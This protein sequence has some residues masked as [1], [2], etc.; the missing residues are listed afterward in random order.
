MNKPLASFSA[1]AAKAGVE[2]SL[3]KT[4][5]IPAKTAEKIL[6]GLL[7]RTP[8]QR[9]GRKRGPPCFIRLMTAL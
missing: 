5:S 7:E 8:G 3:N 9:Q 4:A 1:D 6:M 2:N